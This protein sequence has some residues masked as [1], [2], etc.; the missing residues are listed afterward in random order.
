MEWFFILVYLFMNHT[1]ILAGLFSDYFK[2]DCSSILQL[3]Q[4][5]S[6]RIYFRLTGTAHTAIGTYGKDAKENET[7]IHHTHQFHQKQIAVPQV[8]IA[9][10]NKQYYLQED[11]GD[12][13]LYAVIKRD[14][15]SEEVVRYLKEV[16]QQLTYLQIKGAEGFDFS[17]CYPIQE[18]NKSS[19]FWDLNGF[20][21][22][23]ARIARV[24]FSEIE[25]NRD[26][27]ALCDYLLQEPH[28]FFMF[29]DC[30]SR[31]VMIYQ[32]KP[33]FIDYQGGRKGALQYDAA[34]L[35]WQAGAKIPHPLR[36]ELFEF[37]CQ[38][39]AA[40]IDID[41]EDFKERYYGFV[42]IRMLQVL[43]AYGFRGL[44]EKRS[45]FIESIVPALE[46]VRW[47]LENVQLKIDLPEL[48]SVLQQLIV[49]DAFKEEK[50]DGSSRHLKININSFSYRRGIPSDAS[51]NGGGFVFDCRG[52]HNPGRYEAYKHLTGKDAP[53]M[54]FL[55]TKS[56]VKEFLEHVCKLIDINIQDYLARDFEH[57]QINF[58]CTGGQHRSVYCAEQTARYI[59]EKYRVKVQLKHIERELQGQF[60]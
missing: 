56:K 42:L 20:K 45:H 6:D 35:L 16:L 14:G 25:L 19:M 5:G 58:G 33:Y 3:P 52:L 21:Y 10:E 37:Y 9:S 23:F 38:K 29:R 55:E 30:Q 59:Q 34:S 7:F 28:S 31:N 2:E 4:A 18:F 36:E 60:I 32:D 27:H 50:F 51:G 15:I 40:L 43:G 8:F 12:I 49:S 17:A 41:K 57:L 24:Q 47:F 26:F 1:E 54:E 22:Y 44:I 11:L 13:S 39:V 53:V 48:K 46:N